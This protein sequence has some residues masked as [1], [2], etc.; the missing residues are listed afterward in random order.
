[1]KCYYSGSESES[2]FIAGI[3]SS[4]SPT[5]G[6]PRLGIVGTEF[7]GPGWLD[8]GDDCE[9]GNLGASITDD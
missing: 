2:K 7:E 1:M 6:T 5:K 8:F 3:S 9:K 4:S